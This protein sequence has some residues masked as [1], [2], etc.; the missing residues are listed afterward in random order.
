MKQ[1]LKRMGRKIRIWLFL[2]R[3]GRLSREYEK[4]SSEMERAA[5]AVDKF[6]RAYLDTL[7][8]WNRARRKELENE[9][10]P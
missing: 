4:L 1:W 2:H 7:D 10:K 3:I 6:G 9:L 8:E 5:W